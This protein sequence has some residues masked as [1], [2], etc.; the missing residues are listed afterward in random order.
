MTGDVVLDVRGL[1]VGRAGGRR[2]AGVPLVHGVD[3]RLCRGEV[4][5]LVG[6]SG[7]G[8]SL[9]ALALLGLCPPRVEA[10]GGETGSR[11]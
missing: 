10:R 11:V 1:L 6:E 4:L 3:L 8:K 5:G 7:A 9:T 2:S